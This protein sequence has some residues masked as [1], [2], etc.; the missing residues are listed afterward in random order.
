MKQTN[1]IHRASL[2]NH[3]AVESLKNGSSLGPKNCFILNY[4]DAIVISFPWF[5]VAV[6]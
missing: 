4:F 2:H 6:Q 3:Q 5:E 1:E